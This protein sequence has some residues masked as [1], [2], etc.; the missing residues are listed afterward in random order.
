MI[1]KVI[2]A[3]FQPLFEVVS[4]FFQANGE[5]LFLHRR[6]GSSQGGRWG[7]PG[8]KVDPGETLEEAMAREIGEET[9]I[10]IERPQLRY[11]D[12][13]PVEHPGRQFMYHMFSVTMSG[14]PLVR[15]N[16]EHQGYQ[17][18][19]LPEALALPL[20]EDGDECLRM[21]YSANE[22]DLLSL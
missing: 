16:R 15:L 8:G 5:L 19:S 11:F 3:N 20:V 21:F 10:M 2:P 7:L 12:T 17:W 1:Y 18:V 22:R 6:E 13:V 9:G 14:K 4:C